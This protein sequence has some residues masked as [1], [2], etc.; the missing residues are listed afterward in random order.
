MQKLQELV[1]F[2]K[3]DINNIL[4]KMSDV[5]VDSLA[6]GAIQ[7]DN[8]G[9]VL[10]FNSAEATITGRDK[11]AV[12]GKN[13]FDEVAPCTKSPTFYGQFQEGVKTGH[14]DTVFEYLF[15]YKMAPTK[16]KVYMKK[17]LVGETF[18]IFVK[19]L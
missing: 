4:A 14:L 19:R 11:N 17:A 18:W 8:T 2:D 6:F 3:T 13:F 16:V 15:D 7:I 12:I 1:K 9:K 10:Q 5:Q